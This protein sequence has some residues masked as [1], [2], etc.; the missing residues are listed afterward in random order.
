MWVIANWKMNGNRALCEQLAE[1]LRSRQ[2]DLRSVHIAVCPPAVLLPQWQQVAGYD[3]IVLGAQD[4][5][6]HGSG[7]HTGE[8]SLQLLNETGVSLVLIGHSERRSYYGDSPRVAAKLA[9]V[10]NQSAP[11]MTAVLCVGESAAERSTETTFAVIEAQLTEALSELPL[12]TAEQ[13]AS[14]LIIAYE[15]V[16]AIGTGVTASPEQAQEV[17][18]FIRSWLTAKLQATGTKI[19]L[20]YGGSVNAENASA[21]FA[22]ADID[23]GLIGGASLDPQAF[24]DICT[25]A[26][27]SE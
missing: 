4:V 21:L 19:P 23:G 26:T 5:N 27:R 14:R 18:Q 22:E 12:A 7:A 25:A 16:W 9:A 15:P 8:H 1:A 13:W 11:A 20:L 24:V 6:E 2:D 17:H 3:D 10:L